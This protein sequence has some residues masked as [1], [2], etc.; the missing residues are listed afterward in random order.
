MKLGKVTKIYRNILRK[1]QGPEFIEFFCGLG[2]DSYVPLK[3][4]PW[5]RSFKNKATDS[6]QKEE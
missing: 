2:K 6:S 5:L 1:T 3:T 4:S